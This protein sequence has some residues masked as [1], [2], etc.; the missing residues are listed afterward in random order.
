LGCMAQIK[1]NMSRVFESELIY[2]KQTK[3]ALACFG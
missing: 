2:A 3:Q 1:R